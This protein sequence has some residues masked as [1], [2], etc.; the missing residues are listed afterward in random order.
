MK[1]RH[2]KQSP[3]QETT[4]PDNNSTEII[5]NLINALTKTALNNQEKEQV[6]LLY[7]IGKIKLIKKE[8]DNKLLQEIY[9]KFLTNEVRWEER[10]KAI[11]EIQKLKI[12][13][14]AIAFPKIK[15]QNDVVSSSIKE[16]SAK[17]KIREEEEEQQNDDRPEIMNDLQNSQMV[18]PSKE[19][20]SF[21]K[22]N[23]KLKLDFNCL[24]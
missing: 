13:G 4:K 23:H 12:E 19:S 22:K 15:S 14:K 3:I 2:A 18:S 11:E 5:N 7:L 21:V 1:R 8:N 16:T 6:S 9:V 24:N 20:Y 17:I 10:L